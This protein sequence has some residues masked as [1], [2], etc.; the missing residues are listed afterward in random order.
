MQMMFAEIEFSV[1]RFCDVCLGL[2]YN[3]D[4]T[5]SA[6]KIFFVERIMKLIRSIFGPVFLLLVK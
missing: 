2:I 1:A 4:F 5:N 3:Q 6:N